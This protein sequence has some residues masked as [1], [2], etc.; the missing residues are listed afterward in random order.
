MEAKWRTESIIVEYKD[1]FTGEVTYSATGHWFDPQGVQVVEVRLA[2]Y[3]TQ[4][5]LSSWDCSTQCD[6]KY[7]ATATPETV[8]F[9]KGAAAA[10]LHHLLKIAQVPAEIPLL[11]TVTEM[12]GDAEVLQHREGDTP[13]MARARL[14]QHYAKLGFREAKPDE[15]VLKS[16]LDAE[17][18]TTV[19]TYLKTVQPRAE[20]VVLLSR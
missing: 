6:A 11:A 1:R 18:I 9:L 4:V 14:L 3:P 19:G 12:L 15:A 2:L 17:V 13:G 20:H 8:A 10:T 7:R 5:E 16:N